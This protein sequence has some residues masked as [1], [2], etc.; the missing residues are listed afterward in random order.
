MS[1][2]QESAEL[3]PTR[4]RHISESNAAEVSDNLARIR[5]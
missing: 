3:D 2:D 1:T 4:N 5:H